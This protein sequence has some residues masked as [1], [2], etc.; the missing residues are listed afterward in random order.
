M[1]RVIVIRHLKTDD[2]QELKFGSG[3]RNSKVL[4][5]QELS[6][7]LLGVLQGISDYV[8]CHTGLERTI[9]TAQLIAKHLSYSG[10]LIELTEFKERFGGELAGKTLAE[11]QSCFRR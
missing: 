9:E 6:D 8:I 4:P 2:N 11:I 1:K 7:E 10:K 3:D 5:G